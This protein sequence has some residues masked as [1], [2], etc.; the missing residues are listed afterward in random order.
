MPPQAP[1]DGVEGAA[2]AIP[3]IDGDGIGPADIIMMKDIA[4][5]ADLGVDVGDVVPDPIYY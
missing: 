1:P 3:D 5:V 4:F 2:A